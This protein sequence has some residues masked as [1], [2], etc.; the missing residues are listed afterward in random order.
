[1]QARNDRR[2]GFRIPARANAGSIAAF[3]ITIACAMMLA[4]V[5]DAATVT[6]LDTELLPD[7]DNQLVRIEISGGEL[8]RGMNLRLQLGDG[9]GTRPEPVFNGVNFDGTIWDIGSVTEFGGPVETAE[10]FLQAGVAL[11]TADQEIPASGLAANLLVDTTD[12]FSGEFDLRLMET[13]IGQDTDL[14]LRNGHVLT[15]LLTNTRL[16]I[17]AVPEPAA[18]TLLIGSISALIFLRRRPGKNRAASLH[19]GS[20]LPRRIARQR[21]R[22]DLS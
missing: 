1:M 14:V 5:S 3:A 7:Q 16:S 8:V 11:G 21:G 18:A 10:M 15:P 19:I 6:V 20:S 2:I 12:F 9:L 17:V 4:P 13:Q 22:D